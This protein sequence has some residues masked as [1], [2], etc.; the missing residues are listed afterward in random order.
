MKGGSVMEKGKRFDQEQ[1]LKILE[2]AKEIRT[3]VALLCI[4]DI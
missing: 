3:L 4:L 2:T 1:K